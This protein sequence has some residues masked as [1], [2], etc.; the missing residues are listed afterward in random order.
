MNDVHQLSDQLDRL[1]TGLPERPDVAAVVAA[2]RRRRRHR[3]LAVTAGLAVAA[4]ALATPFAVAGLR[5][6]ATSEAR[7]AS[8]QPPA[9]VAP[10]APPAGPAGAAFGTGVR[11]A[12][13]NSVPDAVFVRETLADSF[14]R[15]NVDG[16]SVYDWAVHSPPTWSSLF[17][18][19]QDYT[20]PSGAALEV[21][22]SW[23]PPVV[24]EMSPDFGR[25]DDGAT[26]G[27]CDS[28]DV[29]GGRLLVE[30]GL[31]RGAPDKWYR[32]VTLV[33]P[34]ATR[35]MMPEVQVSASVHALSWEEAQTLLPAVADLTELAQNPALVLPAPETYPPFPQG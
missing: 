16:T 34:S 2:G 22:S 3:R 24:T 7:V 28:S 33:D 10:T 15:A 8:D 26:V 18:W 25:C 30:D 17:S 20:L 19:Q 13:L 31:Q 12:V 32:E 11:A 4:V 23:T 21:T 29:P 14:A 35:G 9:Y 6:G 27:S 5:T 1:D